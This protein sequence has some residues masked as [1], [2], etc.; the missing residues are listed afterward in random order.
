MPQPM[1]GM[2]MSQAGRTSGYASPAMVA[3]KRVRK[4]SL[5][6]LMSNTTSANNSPLTSPMLAPLATLAES[7]TLFDQPMNVE[8]EGWLDGHDARALSEIEE[9]RKEDQSPART[10][11]LSFGGMLE[12]GFSS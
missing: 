11:D 5:K 6:T 2:S 10:G 12:I 8:M 7:P 1:F 3:L 4:P 9:G